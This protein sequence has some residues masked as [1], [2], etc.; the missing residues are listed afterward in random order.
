MTGDPWEG[1]SRRGFDGLCPP[2]FP[3]QLRYQHL[4]RASATAQP[5]LF[6]WVSGSPLAPPGCPQALQ[7]RIHFQLPAFLQSPGDLWEQA[8]VK[9]KGTKPGVR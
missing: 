1:A 5:G 8:D 7:K 9:W 3:A 6:R 2:G 4:S